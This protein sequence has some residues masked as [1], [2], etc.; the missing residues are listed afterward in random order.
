MFQKD[1][2]GVSLCGDS[3]ERGLH[4][5]RALGNNGV[6]WAPGPKGRPRAKRLRQP[7]GDYPKNGQVEAKPDVGRGELDVLTLGPSSS[8][9]A[10]Q[11]L[12]E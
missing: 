10:C 9:H 8:R 7:V 2:F 3:D 6:T 4:T 12:P 11:A 1:E 5:D